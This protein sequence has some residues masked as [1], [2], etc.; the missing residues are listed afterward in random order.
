MTVNAV[1]GI[2][3]M[4]QITSGGAVTRTIVDGLPRDVVSWVEKNSTLTLQSA[5][6]VYLGGMAR[7]RDG[8]LNELGGT[9]RASQLITVD[10]GVSTDDEVLYRQLIR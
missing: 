8:S 3:V 1:G 2:S 9:F 10:S 7:A 6:Q 5:A 4:G